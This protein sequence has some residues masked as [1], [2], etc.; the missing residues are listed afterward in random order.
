MNDELFHFGTKGM[1]HGKRLYQ[2]PD[3]TYT[4]LGK[5]R[6]RVTTTK[7]QK[8]KIKAAKAAA[9]AKAREARVQARVKA[10][11]ERAM[12][13]QAKKAAEEKRKNVRQYDL[14]RFSNEEL[15]RLTERMAI[16]KKFIEAR[17]NLANINPRIKTRGEK[18]KDILR[19]KLVP[20]LEDYAINAGMNYIKSIFEKPD[21]PNVYSEAKREKDYYQNLRDAEVNKRQYEY[22]KANPDVIS[23]GKDKNQNNNNNQNDDKN[24]KPKD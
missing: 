21:A 15:E 11:Q 10:R 13:A 14:S 12:A 16:E 5:L 9:R 17:T 2:N 19:E 22:L 8:E 20:K 1:E 18:F 4:E 3:G 6:R 23:Y 7:A 24:K